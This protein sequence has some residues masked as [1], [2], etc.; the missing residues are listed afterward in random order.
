MDL[1]AD[2]GEQMEIAGDRVDSIQHCHLRVHQLL[3]G[4]DDPLTN[5]IGL[6]RFRDQP[7]QLGQG[8]RL[9]PPVFAVAEQPRVV[10][11]H[12]RAPREILGEREVG[13]GIPPAGALRHERDHAEASS[14][15]Y[16][17]HHHVRSDP[18]RSHDRVTPER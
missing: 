7:A 13:C 14:P 1:R 5:D 3:H 16:E 2:A 6:Q 10:D 11:G 15:C 17:R 9:T 4:L 18:K 8:L 12:R